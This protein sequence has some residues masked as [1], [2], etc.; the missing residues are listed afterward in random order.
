MLPR[1]KNLNKL[2]FERK[3]GINKKIV[4]S[5][6]TDGNH[7]L[8]LHLYEGVPGE[9]IKLDTEVGD[10]IIVVING[11]LKVNINDVEYHVKKDM[12]ILLPSG[13]SYQLIIEGGEP[14][15]AFVIGCE[16]CILASD[17]KKEFESVTE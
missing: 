11:S 4:F 13:A 10:E 12:S 6:N 1:L 14:L 3:N 5:P 17:L 9:E 7:F 2:A 16:Q 8:S 15:K